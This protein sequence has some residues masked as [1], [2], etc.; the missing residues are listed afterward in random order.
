[1]GLFSKSDM[2][3]VDLDDVDQAS[4]EKPFSQANT[5]TRKAI[6]SGYGVDKAIELMRVLPQNDLDTVVNIVMHTLESMHINVDAIVLDAEQKESRTAERIQ[7]L[8]QEIKTLGE[9]IKKH[10]DEI[11][12]CQAELGEVTAIKRLLTSTDKPES[13]AAK[14]SP[15]F[16]Q[17]DDE[18]V[19]G[20]ALIGEESD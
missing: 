15:E 19:D 1:M 20:V 5:G 18:P 9:K 3:E 7:F 16:D 17:L 6:T 12:I 2:E 14:K 8:Q 10:G 13:G 4:F 11:N